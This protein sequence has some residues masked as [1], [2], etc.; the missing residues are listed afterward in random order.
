[1]SLNEYFNKNLLRVIYIGKEHLNPFLEKE[2]RL[3]INVNTPLSTTRYKT[4]C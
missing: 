1:M 3:K 2:A 4:E